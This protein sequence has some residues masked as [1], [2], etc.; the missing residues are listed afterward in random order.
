MSSQEQKDINFKCRPLGFWERP[1][2]PKKFILSISRFQ[3]KFGICPLGFGDRSSP[4]PKNLLSFPCKQNDEK[5]NAD[6]DKEVK[7]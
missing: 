6:D 7:T 3:D 4:S 1:H 5:M 2:R